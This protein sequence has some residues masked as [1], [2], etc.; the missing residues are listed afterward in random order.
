MNY[1]RFFLVII[2]FVFLG[3]IGLFVGVYNILQM[4]KAEKRI[5]AKLTK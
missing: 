4:Q 3:W 2:S 5:C 1:L